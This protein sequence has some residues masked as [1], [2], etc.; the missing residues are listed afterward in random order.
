MAMGGTT[1]DGRVTLETGLLPRQLRPVAGGHARRRAARP[2]RRA[3]V[4]RSGRGGSAD[5]PRDLRPAAMPPPFRWAPKRSPRGPAARGSRAARRHARAQR[6]AAACSGWSR[7]VE[8]ETPQGR[9]A[10]GRSPPPTCRACSTPASWT[11]PTHPLRL[12]LGSKRSLAEGQQRLTFARCGIIDPLS[13]A[14]YEAHGG[15]AGL[16]RALDMAPAA[17]VEEVTA[18]GLRGRGGAG[19]PTGIKWRTVPRPRP[20]QKYIVCNADEGDSGTFA[21]RMLME[22]DPFALIE[23]MAIAGIAVGATKGYVYIRSEYPHA[24]RTMR[25]AIEIARGSGL[26]GTDVL[27]SGQASIWRP[28]WARAP[29]SAARRP[30]CWRAWKASAARSG[31]KPPLPAI[32]R[33]VRQADRRQQPGLARDRADHPGRGRRGLSRLRHGPLARHACRSSWPATSSRAA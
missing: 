30:R 7:C 23:G 20:T 29:T 12:G 33:P 21:D 28:G 4:L 3:R 8:V 6:L 13:L 22:G 9:S 5:E 16:R 10:T 19:F 18:S 1:P 31:L 24:F 14:D 2:G 32:E 25:R 27:G 26:L 15:L 11:V 17:I